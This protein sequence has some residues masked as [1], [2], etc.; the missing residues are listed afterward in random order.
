MKIIS[1]IKKQQNAT[2]LSTSTTL[3]V[4]VTVETKIPVLLI[5][6]A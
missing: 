2:V 4:Y 1:N 5:G 3:K 6:V